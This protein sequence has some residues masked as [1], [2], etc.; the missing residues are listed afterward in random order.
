MKYL[1]KI[2]ESIDRK[3]I[4]FVSGG[5]WTGTYFNGELID[6]DNSVNYEKVLKSLGYKLNSIYIRE[7]EIWD[8]L[9]YSCPK[10]LEDIEIIIASKKYNI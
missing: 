5:D 1:K 3:E 2:N 7:E 6:E 8:K 10:N 9:G 4:T